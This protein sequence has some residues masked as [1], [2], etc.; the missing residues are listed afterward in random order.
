MMVLLIVWV[1]VEWGEPP[2]FLSLTAFL[3]VLVR[4]IPRLV[5][6]SPVKETGSKGI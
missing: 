6:T 4:L 5:V 2:L 3:V 1:A